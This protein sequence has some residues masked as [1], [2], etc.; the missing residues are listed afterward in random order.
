M[1]EHF[2]D[3]WLRPGTRGRL[4]NAKKASRFSHISAATTFEHELR[5]FHDF[6]WCNNSLSIFWL[7]IQALI[8]SMSVVKEFGEAKDFE[9]IPVPVTDWLGMS[10]DDRFKFRNHA[11]AWPEFDGL[12]FWDPPVIESSAHMIGGGSKPFISGDAGLAE[13]YR[14]LSSQYGK[15]KDL[16][17]GY[18]PIIDGFPRVTPRYAYE[19]SALSAQFGAV[20]TTYGEEEC[21]EFLNGLGRETNPVMQAFMTVLRIVS[22]QAGEDK[23]RFYVDRIDWR[24]VQALGF[25]CLSGN[26][27]LDGEDSCPAVRLSAILEA[28]SEN[29]FKYLPPLLSRF[30]LVEHWSRLLGISAPFRSIDMTREMLLVNSERLV[31]KFGS[32]IK[33]SETASLAMDVVGNVLDANADMVKELKNDPDNYI[34]PGK[35]NTKLDRWPGGPTLIDIRGTG[36]E[37]VEN[38]LLKTRACEPTSQNQIIGLSSFSNSKTHFDIERNIS[39]RRSF[40]AMDVLFDHHQVSPLDEASAISVFKKDYGKTLLFLS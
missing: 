21:A 25:W 4:P 32:E 11:A 14:L 19:I 2:S 17:E 40:Q 13:L 30:E 36:H 26:Y 5:H 37:F 34:E 9:A 29:R 8:N 31:A 23:Q 15:I 7:R 28:I 27:H 16:R 10:T 1:Y 20:Y 35:Y 39:L 12:A 38:E 3:L 18:H 22:P 33:D 24:A 6:L